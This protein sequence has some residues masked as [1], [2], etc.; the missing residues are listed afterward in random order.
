MIRESSVCRRELRR[1]AG[2]TCPLGFALHDV[3][4]VIDAELVGLE[5]GGFLKGDFSGD[6]R[7][8][9]ACICGRPFTEEDHWQVHVHR[10]Y[11]GAPDGKLYAL[12]D[13][14]LPPGAMWEAPS[15][16]GSG[17]VGQDGKSIVVQLPTGTAFPIDAPSHSGGRWTRTGTPPQITVHPSIHEVGR[18]HGNLTDGILGACVEGNRFPQYPETA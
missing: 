2:G 6:P 9:K 4:V 3:S 11:S 18:Y 5:E 8:P 13:K 7:W 14:D 12:H 17:W 15:Y 16:T 1:Y 10:L